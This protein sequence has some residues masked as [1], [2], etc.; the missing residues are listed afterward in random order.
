M[1]GQITEVATKVASGR[2]GATL[3]GPDGLLIAED[4]RLVGQD[5]AHV[6]EEGLHILVDD[7]SVLLGLIPVDLETSR[8][9]EHQVLQ[10]M[11]RTGRIVF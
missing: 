11:G 4:S 1:I 5:S 7:D 9:V 8:E 6:G 3:A 2:R 10:D